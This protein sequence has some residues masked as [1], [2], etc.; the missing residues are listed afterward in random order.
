MTPGETVKVGDYSLVYK[1]LRGNKEKTYES[2]EAVMEVYDSSGFLAVMKPSKR[3]Y[4]KKA[5][6]GEPS[7]EVAIQQ[8]LKEDL[9]LILA[10]WEQDETASI[11]VIV[12]PLLM[13][14]WIGTGVII[15]GI[16][17]CVLPRRRRDTELDTLTLDLLNLHT[18]HNLARERQ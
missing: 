2:V 15:L 16:L 1:G 7:T 13:W 3:F 10:G 12:N 4:F 18:P 6:K 17:W 5:Q 11:T 8:R 9:Y 14:V